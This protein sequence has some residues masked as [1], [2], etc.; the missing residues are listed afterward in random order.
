[1][2]EAVGRGWAAFSEPE[3]QRRGIEWLDLVRSP[4]LNA[5]LFGLVQEFADTSWRPET[6]RNLVGE[7]EAHGRWTALAA[8]F[9]EHGHF[10]VTNGPYRLEGWSA[11]GARLE[12]FRDLSYPLGVGSFDAYA[13]PRRGW[14]NGFERDG[15]RLELTADLEI[16][17]KFGRSY[18][19]ERQ[20]MQSIAPDL[21]KRAAPE[22]RYVVFDADGQAVFAGVARPGED[23]RFT[24]DFGGKLTDGR[25]TLAVEIAVN[26]NAMNA[27][28]RRFEFAVP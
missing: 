12:A 8:F 19:L 6:L 22:C 14:V 25:Y 5:K 2:E 24:I 27:E 21:L 16:L 17:V 10:L 20:P 28:I 4:A 26:A 23:R 7:D 9:K 18:H 13:I 3:A 15:D 1:M 11:D